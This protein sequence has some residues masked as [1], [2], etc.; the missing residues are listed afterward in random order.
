M[1]MYLVDLVSDF[2][3]SEGVPAERAKAAS[4]DLCAKVADAY[5]GQLLYFPKNAQGH[6][7]ALHRQVVEKFNGN[8]QAALALEFRI[9]V[10]TVYRILQCHRKLMRAQ[11]PPAP[12]VQR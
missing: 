3:T 7:E 9:T 11:Q 6:T 10:S 8:N 12:P 5:G 1:L 2:L 4:D